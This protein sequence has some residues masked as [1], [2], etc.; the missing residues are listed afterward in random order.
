MND[1]KLQWETP[2]IEIEA[3][4]ANEYVAACWGVGCS[5]NDA[6]QIE[7]DFGVYIQGIWIM[8]L[9][10]AAF[11]AIRSFM[12]IIMTEPLTAWSKSVRM[13]WAR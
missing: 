4:E 6:N 1:M 10:I 13:D 2:R 9:I 11:P 12:T 3:F 8:E 7:M 5:V